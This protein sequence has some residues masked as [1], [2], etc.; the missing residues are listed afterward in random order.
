MKKFSCG[1]VVPGCD[2]QFTGDSVESILGQV[3]AHAGADHGLAT[4]PP[5][6][7]DEVVARIR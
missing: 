2:A 4:V 1:D 5:E 7:A 6:L 3:A